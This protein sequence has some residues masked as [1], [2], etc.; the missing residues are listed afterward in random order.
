M[1]QYAAFMP[2]REHDNGD[3]ASFTKTVTYNLRNYP[4]S[5]GRPVYNLDNKTVEE[6]MFFGHTNS[7]V[8][9]TG[10][11]FPS[12][13]SCGMRLYKKHPDDQKWTLEVIPID[14]YGKQIDAIE[15]EIKQIEIPHQYFNWLETGRVETTDFHVL[16][17]TLMNIP[18]PT[19]EKLHEQN[20]KA[21]NAEHDENTYLSR[22]PEVKTLIVGRLGDLLHEKTT[23]LFTNFKAGTNPMSWDDGY[24]AKFR[25]VV[26]PELWTLR[27]HMPEN[28]AGQL[29]G[30]YMDIIRVATED[31]GSSFNEE[32][33]ISELEKIEF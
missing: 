13:Q 17:R 6:K 23:A 2:D 18:K 10:Y 16:E 29:S 28:R 22:R 24:G 9:Y 26:G 1:A 15:N 19:L 8:E 5:L 21:Y 33:Y 7:P 11:A 14:N 30:L 31:G 4:D 32:K 20:R 12:L 27:V 25:C 3:G